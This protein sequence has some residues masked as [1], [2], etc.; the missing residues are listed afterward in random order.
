MQGNCCG[1][2]AT[3]E[4]NVFHTTLGGPIMKPINFLH[5]AWSDAG[6]KG[7]VIFTAICSS[8]ATQVGKT[9]TEIQINSQRQ[10]AAC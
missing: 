5:L 6:L 7:P 10:M 8:V 3:A 2:A 1:V 9:D 4:T